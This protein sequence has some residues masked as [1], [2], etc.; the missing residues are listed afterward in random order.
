MLL[1]LTCCLAAGITAQPPAKA[2]Y[3]LKG[4]LVCLHVKHDTRDHN[5]FDW[6]INNSIII[7]D[8]G[9]LN[10]NYASNVYYDQ[11]NKSLCIRKANMT[12][13]GLYE[14]SIKVDFQRSVWTYDL[15]VQEAV[16]TPVLHMTV[17]SNLSDASCNIT[18]NCSV[19]D[20]WVWSTCDQGR[21]DAVQKSLTEVNITVSSRGGQIVCSGNNHVS[22]KNV[23]RHIEKKCLLGAPGTQPETPATSGVSL[24]YVLGLLLPL[25]C[26][27]A[28]RKFCCS[29]GS[30]AKQQSLPINAENSLY[31]RGGSAVS[32][33]GN[34]HTATG[35]P[36]VAERHHAGDEFSSSG[37]EGTQQRF[38]AAHLT[39]PN[40]AESS[41]KQE[42]DTIYS[43]LQ[44]PFVSRDHRGNTASTE[45][46]QEA[47]AV[48]EAEAT[49][50]NCAVPNKSQS[51]DR[52]EFP[53]KKKNRPKHSPAP[54][55]TRADV[56][57]PRAD[58]LRGAREG[59]SALVADMIVHRH[60]EE[61][62]GTAEILE[63][64]MQDPGTAASA[65]LHQEDSQGT[66][67]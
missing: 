43:L 39:F 20:D 67:R 28:F 63:S 9:L 21:C 65:G 7:V 40:A 48:S 55:H 49:P 13:S 41:Q 33:T 61:T 52:V 11:E 29:H 31:R 47:A 10:P 27:L 18:V 3:G 51:R 36:P 53:P 6:T 16:S 57:A 30:F 32:Q 62:Q 44:Q 1:L 25:L 38:H 66:A 35:G 64:G 60:E 58:K 2:R 12:D 56:A 17:H 37:V 59:R 14:A 45:M 23:S 15:K 34:V 46:T 50:A 24:W 22:R 54:L 8:N 5:G 19:W 4:S 26:G 42:V